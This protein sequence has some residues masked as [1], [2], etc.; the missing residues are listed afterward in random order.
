MAE[1]DRISGVDRNPQRSHTVRAHAP[2]EINLA[3]VVDHRAIDDLSAELAGSTTSGL[4]TDGI[5]LIES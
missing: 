1:G 4:E 5:F 2:G 3:A